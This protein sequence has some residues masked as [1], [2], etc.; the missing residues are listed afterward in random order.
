MVNT[1][2]TW[3]DQEEAL[4]VQGWGPMA[5][6]NLLKNGVDGVPDLPTSPPQLVL[7][8]AALVP[9]Q[10][11]VYMSPTFTYPEDPEDDLVG[12]N[13][14]TAD[15]LTLSAQNRFEP[16]DQLYGKYTFQLAAM[17]RKMY[18][19]ADPIYESEH[20]HAGRWHRGWPKRP[21]AR[22]PNMVAR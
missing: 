8:F 2:T 5:A 18:A 20:M 4:H 1:Y 14:T 15:D 16:V 17:C 13:A 19:P 11:P 12:W 7:G 21:C 10:L 6:T 9:L 22:P 3:E